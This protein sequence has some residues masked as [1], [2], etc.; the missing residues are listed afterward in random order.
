[1]EARGTIVAGAG[2]AVAAHEYDRA[3]VADDLTIAVTAIAIAGLGILATPR[4]GVAAVPARVSALDDGLPARVRRGLVGRGASRERD[5]P[6]DR[7]AAHW[8]TAP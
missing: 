8:N 7:E 2:G 3:I 1:V 4:V 6:E 5:G